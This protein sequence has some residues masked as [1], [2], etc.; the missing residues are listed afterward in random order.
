MIYCC[1][2]HSFC[3]FLNLLCISFIWDIL[4]KENLLMSR[5]VILMYLTLQSDVTLYVIP[6][7]E[8]DDII[9]NLT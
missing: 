9:A 5:L 2:L 6:F 8:P 7:A 3:L 4:L 1:I